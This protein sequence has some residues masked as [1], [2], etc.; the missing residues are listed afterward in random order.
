MARYASNTQVTADRSRQEI[1]RLLM[2]FGAGQ[3]GYL[4][5]V[6]NN[7]AHI[8]FVYRGLRIR[9]SVSLPKESDFNKTPKGR[10][11][12]DNQIKVDYEK[13]MRRRW[14]SL[15][16]L[17]KAKLVAVEDGVAT[18]EEEFL[19]YILWGNGQTTAEQLSGRIMS[20][21]ESGVVPNLLPMPKE[22]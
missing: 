20:I 11:K 3:F 22:E 12:K 6:Q 16:L 1:E 18:F 2:R 19:P 17:V 8:M 5:D 9:I 15:T 13:E 21:E 4:T 10:R 14:R 7:R